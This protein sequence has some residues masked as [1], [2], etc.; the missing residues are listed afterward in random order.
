MPTTNS[1]TTAEHYLLN[2]T[3]ANALTIS[4]TGGSSKVAVPFTYAWSN[5]AVTGTRMGSI[6]FTAGTSGTSDYSTG[7]F[8]VDGAVVNNRVLNVGAALPSRVLFGTTMTTTISSGNTPGVDDDADA[9][10]INAVLSGTAASG[11]L[12]LAYANTTGSFQFNGLGQSITLD[13]TAGTTGLTAGVLNL[14]KTALLSN[15]EAAAVGASLNTLNLPYSVAVVAPR[16]LSVGLPAARI[17]GTVLS[18]GTTTMTV[19]TGSTGLDDN[20]GTRVDVSNT[21]IAATNG[22]SFQYASGATLFNAKNETATLA[23]AFPTLGVSSGTIDLAQTTLLSNGETFSASLKPVVVAY[24]TDVVANRQL[25]ITAP[26]LGTG[27]TQATAA[28]T[29]A[30]SS[31]L[32]TVSTSNDPLVDGQQY[33]T[34]LKAVTGKTVKDLTG[35]VVA[36]VT[37]NLTI[38]TTGQSDAVKLALG[39]KTGNYYGTLNLAGS[40]TTTPIQNGE[41]STVKNV[42]VLPE[43]VSYNVDVLSARKLIVS[44]GTVNAPGNQVSKFSSTG[45]TVTAAGLLNGASLPAFS[46][47]STGDDIHNTRVTVAGTAVTSGGLTFTLPSTYINSAG[48]LNVPVTVTGYSTAAVTAS[49]STSLA[50]NTAEALS[51]GDTTKYTSIVNKYKYQVTDVGIATAATTGSGFGPALVANVAAVRSWRPRPCRCRRRSI[52]L[53]PWQTIP[54]P[55]DR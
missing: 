24:N 36:S 11:S 47:S 42:T 39:T 7:S 19:L 52:R 10:R 26:N 40:G 23:V 49:G 37:G 44:G 51:V 22:V 46:L 17:V 54:P 34:T 16:Q 32:G 45:G 31:L 41:A 1:V 33:A 8:I 43:T 30:G 48:S 38:S 50:V 13:I 21:A 2:S 53:E 18:G 15:G 12:K 6:T 20:H 5:V 55:W 35:N 29:M 27:T 9:T 4:P 14:A 28:R 3:G 25:T